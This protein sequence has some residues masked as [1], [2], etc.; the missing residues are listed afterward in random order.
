MAAVKSSASMRGVSNCTQPGGVLRWETLKLFA[1]TH[2][3]VS[4]VIS[5]R[6]LQIISCSISVS[7]RSS[8]EIMEIWHLA[9]KMERYENSL[10]EILL[11]NLNCL[12]CNAFVQLLGDRVTNELAQHSP[13]IGFTLGGG[14]AEITSAFPH[15]RVSN[16][17]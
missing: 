9:I 1:F 11:S 3:K 15:L 12:F 7:L 14:C 6:F 8:V 2:G 4:K 16:P 5:K 10:N 17:V 13:F